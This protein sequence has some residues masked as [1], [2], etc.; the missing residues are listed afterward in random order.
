ML[1]PTTAA[2]ADF[3]HIYPKGRSDGIQISFDRTEGSVW[4][5][6]QNADSDSAV[7]TT[8]HVKL[9]NSH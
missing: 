6:F 1:A 3:L 8:D 7:A 5:I 4:Q 9:N 2:A